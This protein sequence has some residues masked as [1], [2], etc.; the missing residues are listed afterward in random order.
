[1]K[2]KV[3]S[4]ANDYSTPI[5]QENMKFYPKI[6]SVCPKDKIAQRERFKFYCILY[7]HL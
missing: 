3:K 5:V 4:H 1:M 7:F 6:A 2:Q